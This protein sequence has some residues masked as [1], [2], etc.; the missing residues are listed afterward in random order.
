MCV[1]VCVCVYACGDM[2][3]HSIATT[4]T[5]NLRVTENEAWAVGCLPQ[6]HCTAHALGFRMADPLPTS[7]PEFR[8]VGVGVANA[9]L[10]GR[11]HIAHR[12]SMHNQP[13]TYAYV[14]VFVCVYVCVCVVCPFV[15]LSFFPFLPPPSTCVLSRSLFLT[16]L[17]FCY[18]YEPYE[19]FF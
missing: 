17:F 3:G 13:C 10:M 1:C 14:Y 12:L 9:G 18:V 15:P 16:L 2:W 6:D 5:W 8:H 4:L 7:A 11:A 19:L